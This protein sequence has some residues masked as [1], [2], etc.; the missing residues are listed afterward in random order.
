VLDI[1]Q[2][3]KYPALLALEL[4]LIF[5]L[6][7]HSLPT[8]TS[9]NSNTKGKTLLTSIYYVV[10]AGQT[11]KLYAGEG[12]EV[13]VRATRVGNLAKNER[14]TLRFSGYL[15]EIPPSG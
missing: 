12:T 6:I 1:T 4:K 11:V 13:L 10:Q 8:T 5:P 7:W 2:E 9:I 3:H 15:M 14:V